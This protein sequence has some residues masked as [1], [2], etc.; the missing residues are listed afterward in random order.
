MGLNA[1]EKYIKKYNNI[2]AFN[3][4]ND[5]IYAR[6]ILEQYD[7]PVPKLLYLIERR[8]DIGRFDWTKL[9][10]EFVIKPS[11]GSQGKGILVLK[12]YKDDVYQK[13]DRSFITKAELE[14][15]LNHIIDGI[16]SLDRSYDTVIIEERLKPHPCFNTLD[17][18]GLPDIR[19]I[20]V[21]MVPVMAMLRIPTK[22]SKGKANIHQ[23]GIAFGID[24]R[25]GMITYGISGSQSI[26]LNSKMREFVIPDFDDV[27]RYSVMSQEASG[28]GYL[29]VDVT[30]DQDHGPLIL[31]LNAQPG[32]EIQN[33]N[34]A[35]LKKRI[36]RIESLKVKNADEGVQIAR[37]LF[38]KG[39]GDYQYIAGDSIIATNELIQV[40]SKIGTMKEVEALVDLSKD[41]SMLEIELAKRLGFK[42]LKKSIEFEFFIKGKKKRT[43]VDLFDKK[44]ETDPNFI[45]GKNDIKGFLIDTS[46]DS[47]SINKDVKKAKKKVKTYSFKEQDEIIVAVDRE[48]KL[49]S[50]LKPIN[51]E[52]EK[53]KFFAANCD[54]NPQFKYKKLSFIP[55][56]EEA[57]LDNLDFDDTA[58]G[59]L[60]AKKRLEIEK[61]IDLLKARGDSEKFTK[62]SKALY[63]EASDSMLRYAKRLLKQNK[64][65][66]RT[67]KEL[68]PEEVIEKIKEFLAK[69]KLNWTVEV[70]K[71]MVANISVSKKSKIF[72]RDGVK[73]SEDKLKSTLVHEIDTHVLTAYNG[74]KQD[75][76]LLNQ[77]MANYL[78]TQEGLAIYNQVSLSQGKFAEE[79]HY[80]S[81]NYIGVDFAMRN[82]FKDLYKFFI[83][84]GYSED[85]AFR[86]SVHI[87]RG[88]SD[89]SEKGGFTKSTVYL[90]G[91]KDIVDFV[92]NRGDLKKL[93]IGKIAL[94]DL[95][96]IDQLQGLKKPEIIPD[97]IL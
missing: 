20:V 78:K 96:L 32:L 88:L 33:A 34:M 95:Q 14:R 87:K 57:R 62:I 10:K 44:S 1:R 49:L 26:T 82:D 77:G 21:N 41:K 31:E 56:V 28:I 2:K 97:V 40:V 17:N 45:L 15:H 29:G 13:V 61:K 54:Y 18:N 60:Y 70:K 94:E 64:L 37:D 25:T 4:A 89:T 3:L 71:G 6:E 65:Q 43:D 7:I 58:K 67:Q 50:H 63:G 47:P 19:V 11:Q 35:P 86:T 74:S 52:E 69:Y 12:H 53:E 55:D 68:E 5:K 83:E 75:Y 51:L 85:R 91:Y 38:S 59:I 84:S 66:I 39:S 93:Y 30:I 72:V 16:Y 90:G 76:K 80:S 42:T 79:L 81:I 92:E 8:E 27:L 46:I 22:A 23:G 48:I 36:D 73:F 9:P 24:L